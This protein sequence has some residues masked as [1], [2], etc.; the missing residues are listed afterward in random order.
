MSSPPA[1]TRPEGWSASLSCTCGPLASATSVGEP[2][3][4]FGNS[5]GFIRISDRVKDVIVSGGE[6][7]SSVE[8]EQA[9]SA[10]PAVLEAAVIGIPNERWGER[11][12]AFVA[13][14]PGQKAEP[15][16]LRDF[17]RGRIAGYKVPEVELV[18]ELPMTSTGKVRKFEL[19]DKEW[20]G[21][22][23]RIQG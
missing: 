13:L 4:R 19:R 23:K 21:H 3:E 12:K 1:T 16:E 7:I 20:A 18:D 8:V 14:K 6:N 17:L 2:L 11:P 9:L 10:H 5:N 22:D 15:D